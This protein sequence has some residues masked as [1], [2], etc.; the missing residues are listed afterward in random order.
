MILVLLAIAQ[1]RRKT[2]AAQRT[3]EEGLPFDWLNGAPVLAARACVRVHVRVSVCACTCVCV[4][5]CVCVCVSV[6]VCVC[7]CVC[8]GIGKSVSM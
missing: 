1:Q 5:L 4:C 6:C 3:P 8:P 7:V 2:E